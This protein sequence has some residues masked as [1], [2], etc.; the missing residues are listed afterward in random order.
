M[1]D[2]SSKISIIGAGI[3]GLSAGLALSLKKQAFIELFEQRE[4]VEEVGAGIQLGPHVTK[5]LYQWGLAP[6][7]R[8]LACFP[9]YLVLNDMKTGE[10]LA[11]LKLVDHMQRVYQAPYMCIHRADLHRLLMKKVQEAQIPIHLGQKCTVIQRE[12]KPLQIKMAAN[13]LVNTDCLIG[14]DGIYSRTRQ[15]LGLDDRI[16]I[17]GHVAYRATVPIEAAESKE[18]HVNVWMGPHCHVVTYPIS[19]GNELN[20]VCVIDQQKTEDEAFV[21]NEH[22]AVRTFPAALRSIVD[23]VGHWQPWPL[24]DRPPLSCASQMGKGAI[25]LLGDAAHPM[26]PYL[27]QGACMAIE[28]AYVLAQCWH[29]ASSIDRA[30]EQYAQLRWRRNAQI[31]KRARINGRIYHADGALRWARNWALKQQGQSLMDMAWLFRGV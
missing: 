29:E 27:A 17:S 30:V 26:R 24:N 23:Q 3:G 13:Q 1:Q 16:H 5:I 11:Q 22:M 21:F 18:H 31:Q 2:S 4:A 28:D 12:K 10:V 6:D 9:S 25:A 7:L 8:L 15:A 20:I 19:K 14:A